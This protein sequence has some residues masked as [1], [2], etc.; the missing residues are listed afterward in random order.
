MTFNE[1]EF[2]DEQE[3]LLERRRQLRRKKR[4]RAGIIRTALVF[5]FGLAAGAVLMVALAR[6][7]P[8]VLKKSPVPT[9]EASSKPETAMGQAGE[10]A[11]DMTGDAAAEDEA[12][13][14][15]GEEIEQIRDNTE[16]KGEKEKALLGAVDDAEMIIRFAQSSKEK[17][18]ENDEPL[19]ENVDEIIEE[20]L[21]E[22]EGSE[23]GRKS[24]DQ[25]I[26]DVKQALIRGD[27]TM[28]AL[29]RL[30]VD[31]IIVTREGDFFFFPI[32]DELAHNSYRRELLTENSDG[33]LD[34]S[35]EEGVS[36]KKGVDVSRY[37]GEIDWEK[38]R[39]SGVDFA[40][41]RAGFRGYG[42]GALQEDET[43][44]PN[45]LAASAQGIEI[46][47]YFFSQAVT[48]DEAREEA[49]LV[50]GLLDGQKIAYPI[51]YDVERVSGG[52]MS[53]LSQE[54]M[55]DICLAFCNRIS[56]AGYTPMIYGNMET[57]LLMLDMKRIEGIEKWLAFYNNDFYF[58]Y[59]YS[60][61]QY[62]ASGSVEGIEGKVDLNLDLKR[63][64]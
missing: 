56:E 20:K 60:I 62:S 64:M 51:V 23:S 8:S 6:Y 52:R 12:S 50:I 4:Q 29:R 30:F 63:Q 48:E 26:E 13:R 34:Y 19:P 3:E 32:T 33:S 38:V 59:D 53:S 55:T 46:G 14:L 43:F 31:Q 54:K 21:P 57:F 40:F 35:D 41:L 39:G 25:L 58:P 36:A 22:T 16:V 37:Q 44:V 2:Y 27:G 15:T 9:A 28:N 17:T 5:V 45:A 61:W 42:S 10:A 47:A 11:G 1:D 24:S 7:L 18:K 49:D